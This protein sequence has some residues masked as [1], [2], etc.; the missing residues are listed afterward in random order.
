MKK[1][2][3]VMIALFTLSITNAQEFSLGA[4]AGVSY[5]GTLTTDSDYNDFFDAVIVP[6]FGVVAELGLSDV[7]S[8]QPEL[9]YS[10]SGFNRNDT[11]ETVAGDIEYDVT[12]KVNYL[13]IPIMAR[14]FVSDAFS[15]DAGPYVS[16]LLSANLDGTV[17]LPPALGGTTT[18]FDKED[19]KEDYNSTDIGFGFGATYGLDNGLFFQARYTLG[20]T[21]INAED[22]SE[23]PVGDGYLDKDD[24]IKNNIFQ[25]SVGYMFM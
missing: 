6:H 4:K 15:I 21:D 20:L 24:Q 5:A 10:P 16:F 17:E 7:F 25:F 22:L 14:Y 23:I 9:L 18:T 12:G 19:M 11:F 1:L 8:I 13:A 2:V 3:L